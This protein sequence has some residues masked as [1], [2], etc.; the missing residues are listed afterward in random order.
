MPGRQRLG[1]PHEQPQ[2]WAV[3]FLNN[4]ADSAPQAILI[5]KR[6]LAGR[7]RTLGADHTDPAVS[8]CRARQYHGQGVNIVP[9]APVAGRRSQLAGRNAAHC[10]GRPLQPQRCFASPLR[11]TRLRRAVDPGDLCRSS[12]PDGEGQAGGQ[13]L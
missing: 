10:P 13:A 2:R 7:E 3:W 12:E 1:P 11:G 6:L 4:L 5:G 9:R 8:R